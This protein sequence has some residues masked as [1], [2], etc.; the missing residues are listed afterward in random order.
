MDNTDFKKDV[1]KLVMDH[2]NILNSFEGGTLYDYKAMENDEQ[3]KL[4]DKIEEESMS[5][6][7]YIESDE[8]DEP[9]KNL[10]KIIGEVLLAHDIKRIA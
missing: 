1:E 2:I 4:F 3:K 6:L 8:R 9:Y 5:R 7:S 10:T